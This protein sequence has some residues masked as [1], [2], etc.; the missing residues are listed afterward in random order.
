MRRNARWRTGRVR[1]RRLTG[2][3]VLVSGAGSLVAVNENRFRVRPADPALELPPNRQ[4]TMIAREFPSIRY[5]V[6]LR[7]G[8]DRVDE[9]CRAFPLSLTTH[10][11]ISDLILTYAAIGVVSPHGLPNLIGFR[12]VNTGAFLAD[13]ELGRSCR[14]QAGEFALLFIE[15]PH[16][17]EI[18]IRIDRRGGQQ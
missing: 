16:T 18:S 15:K 7:P 10:V 3:L 17:R 9:K 12:A 14:R 11:G 4:R 6:I 13:R 8:D 1:C 5:D 2:R